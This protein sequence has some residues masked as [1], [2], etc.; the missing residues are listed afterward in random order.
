[1][2]HHHAL[3]RALALLMLGAV[4]LGAATGAVN[5]PLPAAEATSSITA[6]DLKMHLSFL[7]SDEL[8]GRYT[9]SPSNRVAARYLASQLE[10]YGYRGAARDGSFLQRVPLSYREV[11][12]TVS[13]VTLNVGGSKRDFNYANAF[14]ADVPADMNISGSLVFVG[15]G[16]S[17][18]RNKDRKSTRLNS[19]HRL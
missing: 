1:M 19:S 11:D 7:A 17:S 12:R 2:K 4:T 5:L 18:P 13:R 10:S 15:Y 6:R 16:V 14:L 8:G 9:L 3:R